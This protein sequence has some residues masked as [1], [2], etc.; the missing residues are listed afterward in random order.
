MIETSKHC[1]LIR[2]VVEGSGK[3][4]GGNLWLAQRD[5]LSMPPLLRD[6]TNALSV[7]DDLIENHN[8]VMRCFNN[9]AMVWDG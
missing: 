9:S 6:T 4:G 1:S 5:V 8:G 2:R 3:G 7:V